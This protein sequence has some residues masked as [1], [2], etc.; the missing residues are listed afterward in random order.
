MTRIARA[1]CLSR[2]LSVRPPLAAIA[3]LTILVASEARAQGFTSAPISTSMVP[4]YGPSVSLA[5]TSLDG[6]SYVAYT[7]GYPAAGEVF[8]G[9]RP[10]GGSWTTED[11]QVYASE[12]SLTTTPFAQGNVVS[13]VAFIEYYKSGLAVP[14]GH[15]LWGSRS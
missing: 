8:Y 12:V 1:S 6:R 2:I 9:T 4:I 14:E 15:V 11:T 3:V 10:E 13:N 5:V 7:S